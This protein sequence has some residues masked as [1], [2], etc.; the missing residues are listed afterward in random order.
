MFDDVKP[1]P[2]IRRRQLAFRLAELR[3]ATGMKQD[4][5]VEHTG[6][7]RSTISKMENA[8]QE[9]M[10]KN[11]RLLAAAYGVVAPELDMLV[12]MARESKKIGVMVAHADVAPNF[13]KDF[14]ELEAYA[15]E[16]WSYQAV[17]VDGMLQ[18]PGYIRALRLAWKPDATPEDLEQ[19]VDLRAGRQKRLLD[20]DA[21]TLRVLLD[22]AAFIRPVGGPDVMVEQIKHLVEMSK[23]PNVTLQVIPRA[24][25]AYPGMGR[26]FAILK[27]DDTPGMDVAYAESL[28][29]ATYHEKR[30]E[31]VQH[32]EVFDRI[33]DL[34]LSPTA[35]RKSLA[36]LATTFGSNQR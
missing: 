19:A 34:A 12:R 9:L 4:E 24:V 26:S 1:A 25:G 28:R 23:L 22:E 7:S 5:V 36:T 8:E 20:K 3:K 21:P 15:S 16:V 33:A 18:I 6:L 32:V 29:S 31:V 35:T 14:L 17:V 13:A 2:P 27:F 11:V 10:E 30:H